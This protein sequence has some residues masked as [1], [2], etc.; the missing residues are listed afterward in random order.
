MKPGTSQD[1]DVRSREWLRP[2]AW[3]T[4]QQQADR[5]DLSKTIEFI[6]YFQ[7]E[8]GTY[9][10]S[11]PIQFPMPYNMREAELEEYFGKEIASKITNGEGEVVSEVFNQKRLS[12]VDLKVGGEGMIAFCTTK[13]YLKAAKKALS[14]AV[15][16]RGG[17]NSNAPVTMLMRS[18]TVSQRE[19]GDLIDNYYAGY[20][21][22]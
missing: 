1:D 12:G 4:G 14:E 15:W 21:L 9:E 10:L 18:L 7:R 8:D 2:I 17:G 3:T 5:Y 11:M 16:S 20:K 13:L 6:E 22:K 19:V